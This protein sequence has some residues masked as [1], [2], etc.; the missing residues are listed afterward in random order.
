MLYIIYCVSFQIIFGKQTNIGNNDIPTPPWFLPS[1]VM[2]FVCPW[3]TI[4]IQ[5]CVQDFD[6]YLSLDRK[7]YGDLEQAL[8]I[9]A[10]PI[11]LWPK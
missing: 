1:A 2:H 8:N 9:I 3:Q 5:S 7:T 4:T 11:T 6:L 10:H